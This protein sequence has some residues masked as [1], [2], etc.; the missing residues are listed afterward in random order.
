MVHAGGQAAHWD[1]QNKENSNLSWWSRFVLDAPV[2]SLP[3]SMYHVTASCRRPI[4]LV[5]TNFSEG[6]VRERQLVGDERSISFYTRSVLIAHF[7]K[8]WWPGSRVTD[9]GIVG[10]FGGTLNAMTIANVPP[11]PSHNHLGSYCRP[12]LSLF[13][14]VG[15]C[16]D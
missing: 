14:K 12:R 4:V 2:G 3:S 15:Y 6:L 5:F 13:S 1:I 7:G 9:Q 11:K 8:E 16:K 10:L